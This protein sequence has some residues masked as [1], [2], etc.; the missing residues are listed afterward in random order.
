V[1]L[2]NELVIRRENLS[3]RSLKANV[4]EEFLCVEN[5]ENADEIALLFMQQHLNCRRLEVEP[6]V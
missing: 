1:I 5:Q 4:C 6:E 2:F 3:H